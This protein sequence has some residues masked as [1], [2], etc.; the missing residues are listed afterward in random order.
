MV[1]LTDEQKQEIIQEIE[2]V[3]KATDKAI[4]DFKE[5]TKCL[6][7]TEYIKQYLEQQEKNKEE[8]IGYIE[9]LKAE[10][11]IDDNVWCA[12]MTIQAMFDLTHNKN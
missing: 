12:I 5:N 9:Y 7:D 6:A 8:L 3:V 11:D 2:E 4:E 10:K 1:K